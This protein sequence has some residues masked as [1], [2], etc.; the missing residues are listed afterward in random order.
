MPD[1]KSLIEQLKKLPFITPKYCDNCGFR[2]AEDDAK[3]V[4]QHEGGFVF[5]ISCKSCGSNYI[6]RVNPSGNGVAGQRMEI[7]SDV[8]P[9]ELKKFAGKPKVHREEALEVYADM[10]GVKNIKDF[11]AL[12]IKTKEEPRKSS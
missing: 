8:K 12:F 9:T 4:T 5:Q 11:L 3:F 1:Y 6:M 2:H 7:N 10:K